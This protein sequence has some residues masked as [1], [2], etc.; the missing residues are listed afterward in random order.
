[1]TALLWDQVGQRFYET[2][3]DHGVLYIPDSGGVYDQGFAWNGLVSVTESPSGAEPNPQYADN[4]KYLNLQSYEEFGGTVEAFTYPPEFG[5]CDGTATQDGAI[6]GQQTRKVFGLSYRTKVGNDLNPDLGFKIHMIWGALASPSEKPYTTVNDSPEAVQF[7]WEFTT[8]PVPITGFKPTSYICIPT[9][10]VDSA[11][12]TALMD[13][14]YGTVGTD[15]SLPSPDEV[16][17]LLDGTFTS[18]FPTAPT[19]DSGTDIITIPGT[20]GVVYS[21]DGVVVP[22]GPTAA[23]TAS[24][25]VHARPAAG[26]VF[27]QPSVDEWL[28]TFA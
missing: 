2:G 22:A 9:L 17:A 23:I 18:V 26:Y 24:K 4:I 5:Q 11:A 13:L 8:T 15:P 20:T 6:I 1:M 3:V 28:I 12:L 7:S 27:T 21:I 19:Y 16:L 25:V 14:L 10:D